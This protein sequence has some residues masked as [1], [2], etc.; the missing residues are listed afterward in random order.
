MVIVWLFVVLRK[1]VRFGLDLLEKRVVI[2]ICYVIVLKDGSKLF[3]YFFVF[4]FVKGCVY[5]L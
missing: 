3:V 1:S 4:R 5:K 2:D